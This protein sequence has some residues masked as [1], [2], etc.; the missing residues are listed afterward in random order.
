MLALVST[1]TIPVAVAAM[2]LTAAD[3]DVN[4][5]IA[6]LRLSDPLRLAFALLVTITP[7][8]VFVPILIGLTRHGRG[9]HSKLVLPSLFGVLLVTFF[10]LSGVVGYVVGGIVTGLLMLAVVLGITAASGQW[11]TTDASGGIALLVMVV[12]LAANV[13]TYPVVVAQ[14]DEGEPFLSIKLVDVS[15]SGT[16]Y[17]TDSEPGEHTQLVFDARIPETIV[18][19]L[20]NH[21]LCDELQARSAPSDEE[22][23]ST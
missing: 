2:V 3:G 21:R 5:A 4:T 19:C 17:L 20:H 13:S 12:V 14:F 15:S 10:V 9:R 8:Y 18:V 22:S 11:A 7:A 23:P 16:W 1:V 6:L